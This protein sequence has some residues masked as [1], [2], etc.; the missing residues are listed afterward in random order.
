MIY[1]TSSDFI[2]TDLVISR[3][4][5]RCVYRVISGVCDCVRVSC[6]VRA[7]EGKRLK[8]S[9]PNLAHIYFIAVARHALTRKSKGQRSRSHGY[10]NRHDGSVPLLLGVRR[11]RRI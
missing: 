9:T 2:S 3:Q 5:S 1:H 10:E 7:L 11:A 8:L 6:G 4:H